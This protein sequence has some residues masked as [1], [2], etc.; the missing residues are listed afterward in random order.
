MSPTARLCLI[1]GSS[2]LIVGHE[3]L[4]DSL[5][6]IKKDLDSFAK[7]AETMVLA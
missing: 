1:A 4:P 6:T 3:G 2:G 5:I 7:A